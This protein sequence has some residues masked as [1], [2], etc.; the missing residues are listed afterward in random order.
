[1]ITLKKGLSNPSDFIARLTQWVDQHSTGM[2]FHGNGWNH[3][4]SALA[5]IGV[6]YECQTED[7][8]DIISFQQEHRTKDVFFHINYDVKNDL[9]AL[10]SNNPDELEFPHCSAFVPQISIEV[11][12]DHVHFIGWSDAMDET[13]LD[14]MFQ[15]VCSTV[16]H[17]AELESAPLRSRIDQAQYERDIARLQEHIQRG[18]VYQ[19]NYCQEFI[20]EQAKIAHP[21][22][23]FLEGHKRFPNP[24]AV[25]FK[26]GCHHLL[27]FSPERFLAMEGN[28]ISSQ[29]MKGTMPRGRD[30]SEDELLKNRLAASEKD[31]REN[32]MIVDMVRNDLSHF[33]TKGSVQ[34]PVLYR[35]E[36]YPKVHQMFS[37]VTAELRPG[38]SKVAA[39]LKAFPMGSMT[40]APK[41]RAMEVLDALEHSKR[42]IYSGTVGY[43]RSDECADFNV[44]IRSLVYNSEKERLSYFAGGGITALSVAEDEWEESYVKARPLIE[45]IASC[46]R[47]KSTEPLPLDDARP[48]I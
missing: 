45:L 46:Q 21:A 25:Y 41:V 44:V 35:I 27:S 22:A 42:G 16:L 11:E 24:F 8:I 18:D 39:L 38:T 10:Q 33:A 20:W 12:S 47:N 3:G 34:V 36:T 37:T 7:P 15:A 4:H 1:M 17:Q 28:R 30:A 9:E 31:R 13:S 14:S 43:I 5:A 19:G 32:V 23:L 6:A 26:T 29:P 40:G 48:I 2:V